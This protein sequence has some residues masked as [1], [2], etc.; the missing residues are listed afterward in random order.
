MSKAY[1]PA[2]LRQHVVVRARRCCEYCLL[3][4]DDSYYALQID[5]IISEKHGGETQEANLALACAFCNRAKGSDIGSVDPQ[6]EA[7]VRFYNPRTDRWTEHFELDGA[8]IAPLTDIAR[9]TERL[10]QLNLR[11]RLLERESLRGV[12]RYPPEVIDLAD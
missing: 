9:V 5:H 10:L 6:T 7:F 12:G 4:E 3:F 2:E 8:R 11:E 1:I